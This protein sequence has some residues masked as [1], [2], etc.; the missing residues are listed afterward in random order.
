MLI[1]TL[2]EFEKAEEQIYASDAISL[3]TETTGLYWFKQDRP[4]C[5]TISNHTLDYYFDLKTFLLPLLQ[6]LLDNYQ[7]TIF[8][9]NAKFDMHMLE[10]VG[11][12]IMHK[13]IHCTWAMGRLEKNNR[14]SYSLDKLG[15]EIGY[16]KDDAPK[17]YL[18]KNKLYKWIDIPGKKKRDKLYDFSLIPLEI[19][20]PYAEKDTRITLEVGLNQLAKLKEQ[21]IP[22]Y[23]IDNEKAITKVFYDMEKVGVQLDR[24]Y[25]QKAMEYEEAKK[26]EA[27]S[28]FKEITGID[29]V[30][31]ALA[32]SP[33]FQALGITKP[34]ITDKG[35]ESFAADYLKGLD[36][37]I[38]D[39]I[40]AHREAT[41]RL[42]TYASFGY[43]ASPS[44]II[45]CNLM[46]AGT[47]TGRIS[48]SDPAL[49][50]IEK[51]DEDNPDLEPFNLR[52]CF[53]PREDYFFVMMD[54]DQFEY[55]MMLNVAN[56]LPLIAK[57]K[58]GLDVHTATA[59]MM[60][61]TRRQAKTLNFLLLYGGGTQKLADT[62]KISYDEAANLKAIYFEKLPMVK[63]LFRQV[64]NTIQY[65]G[66]LKNLFGRRYYFDKGFEYKGV[67]YLI[68]GSTA[69]WLKFAMV[70]IHDFLKPYKSRL[71]LQIHDELLFEIHQ[72]EKHIIPH[73]KYFMENV[74]KQRP[75]DLLPYTVGIDYSETSWKDKK[76]WQ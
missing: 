46:Q 8:I 66:Y 14:I 41:K 62:L 56:E 35:N 5:L 13:D 32:L 60:G 68:Q 15:A 74:T 50:C 22:Q 42:G 65:R 23:L 31:S 27:E 7:G 55:R 43:Y 1:Q 45:H 48:V 58:E 12:S 63:Q 57:I 10:S 69:D 21:N 53:V 76:E 17:K 59:L 38:A 28:N 34:P 30:D 64:M 9:Q 2:E 19:L 39:I 44:N 11:L 37:P 6:N 54:F 29:F 61:V 72:T 26:V 49:Q 47:A 24:D 71:L 73:L 20:Q 70:K 16:K 4:F 51:P 52:G 3:D 40:L 75:H 67:N 25:L 18:D 33:I 36:H